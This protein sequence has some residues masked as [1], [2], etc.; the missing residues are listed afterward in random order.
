MSTDEYN[1]IH[2]ELYG[3]LYKRIP[4]DDIEDV[5]QHVLMKW[6]IHRHEIEHMKAYI[7]QSARHRCVDLYRK[8]DRE[9]VVSHWDADTVELNRADEWLED[10][11]FRGVEGIED[12]I[13]GRLLCEKVLHVLREQCT[14]KEIALIE[15]L[16]SAPHPPLGSKQNVDSG[17]LTSYAKENG[18]NVNTVKTRKYRLMGKARSLRYMLSDAT[19]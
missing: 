2:K 1:A 12:L 3:W 6:W 4:P 18:E 10:D 7:F 5:I 8:R 19:V 11:E 9:Q 15:E 14:G 13:C 16:M 17:T